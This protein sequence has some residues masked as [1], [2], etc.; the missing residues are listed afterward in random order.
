MEDGQEGINLETVNLN[1]DEGIKL[2][3]VNVESVDDNTDNE[4][5]EGNN[6]DTQNNKEDNTDEEKENLKKGVNFERKRR[7]EAEKKNKELEARI[8]ALEQANK[9][10]E[11]TTLD[12]LLEAG[13]DE[14]IAKA[15]ATGIEKKQSNSK[16]VEEELADLKFQN[17]LLEKS[18]DKNFENILEQKDEVK[19][20]VDKGLSIE[21]AYYALNYTRLKDE[22][23]NT[24]SEIQRK[25]EAKMQNNQE[26]KEI[27]NNVNSNAGAAVN[28]N[29]TPK[30]SGAELAMAR[31]AGM[32]IEDYLAAKNSDNIKEY[33]EYEKK[34]I[35]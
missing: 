20:L 17:A 7:K 22:P 26:R 25:V 2:P 35:K 3:G 21:Q 1:T 4:L 18:R 5:S 11:K 23:Q 14:N 31:L 15:I 32:S 33:T 9:A 19:E 30:A 29:N 27:L 8:T 10:K 13:V 28:N 6:I 16:K 34:K 24:R 12:E